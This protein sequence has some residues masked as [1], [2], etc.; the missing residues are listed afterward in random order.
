VSYTG[1]SVP[2]G[3]KVVD[4][5]LS[6][7]NETAPIVRRVFE[8]YLAG[9]KMTEIIQYLNEIGAKTTQGNQYHKSTI[10]QIL[11]NKKYIG[12][13][14]YADIE[15]PGGV[16]QIIDDKIFADAQVLLEKNRK[17]PARLKALE[18]NYLLTTSLYSILWTLR[19]SYVGRKRTLPQRLYSP[20]LQMQYR[21]Q[22]WRLQK[23]TRKESIYRG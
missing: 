18:E 23:E 9:H 3:Y 13:Y 21:P 17:A 20:V 12:I 8:M 14:K 15:I 22:A 7:D 6:I 1:S 10:R 11:E 2:L 16:P 5:K 19:K 4:K